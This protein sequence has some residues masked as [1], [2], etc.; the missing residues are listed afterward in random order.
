MDQ[1]TQQN[2]A[3]VEES[4]AAS[5]ILAGQAARLRERPSVFRLEADGADHAPELRAI[6]PGRV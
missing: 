1:D 4:N 5:A 6:A 2:A 3:M